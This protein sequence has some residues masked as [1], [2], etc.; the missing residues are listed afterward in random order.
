MSLNKVPIIRYGTC[1]VC[2]G[3][4]DELWY[5]TDWWHNQSTD[6]DGRKT[7]KFIATNGR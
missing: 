7:G 2:N 1:S 3:P 4:A 6:C 5:H